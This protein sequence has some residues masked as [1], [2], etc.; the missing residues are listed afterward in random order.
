M[1]PNKT[2]AGSSYS[3]DYTDTGATYFKVSWHQTNGQVN[4]KSCPSSAACSAVAPAGRRAT[5][6]DG[7]EDEGWWAILDSNQ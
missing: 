7:S 3:Q 4:N 6:N 2:K 1:Y 5:P